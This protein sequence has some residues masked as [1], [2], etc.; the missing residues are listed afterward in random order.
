MVAE[1]IIGAILGI[2]GTHGIH[3]AGTLRY[4]EIIGD[5]AI[6]IT[7]ITTITDIAVITTTGMIMA[8][9]IILKTQLTHHAIPL[10][11][12]PIITIS[13]IIITPVKIQTDT[14]SLINH[15]TRTILT[16]N[17][18]NNGKHL[19][20]RTRANRMCIKIHRET[21]IITRTTIIG[22]IL[23]LKRIIPIVAIMDGITHHLIILLTVAGIAVHPIIIPIA[24]E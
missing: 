16:I 6:I 23:H 24:A 22:I 1:I 17:P 14:H 2:A 7:I 11:T 20:T 13:T 18:I 12:I 10:I 9:F 15:L 5:G 8:V 19:K 3:G 4:A 21:I